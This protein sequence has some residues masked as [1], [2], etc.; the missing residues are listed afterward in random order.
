MAA[1][2]NAWLISQPG[3]QI[4]FRYLISKDS[5]TVGRS[6]T[7]VALQGSAIVTAETELLPQ[8][9]GFAPLRSSPRFR[10]WLAADDL[11]FGR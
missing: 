8:Q 2:N 11:A 1:P 6:A 7:K 5:T 3:A 4:Q 9:E 10:I